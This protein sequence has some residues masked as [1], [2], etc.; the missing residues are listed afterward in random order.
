MHIKCDHEHLGFIIKNCSHHNWG[1]IKDIT[2]KT[3]ATNIRGW[4]RKFVDRYTVQINNTTV[5]TQEEIEHALSNAQEASYTQDKLL[6]S[7][8][9]APDKEHTLQQHMPQFHIDQLRS[10]VSAIHKIKH[11]T[12]LDDDDDFTNDE[13]LMAIT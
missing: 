12:T 11:G 5:F 9:I 10:V 1:Y 8:S 2:P 6:I 13:I 7:I 3:T 4:K